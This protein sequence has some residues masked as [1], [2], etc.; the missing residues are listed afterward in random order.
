[1][2]LIL[3]C[4]C[5]IENHIWPSNK[6]DFVEEDSNFLLLAVNFIKVITLDPSE[7]NENYQYVVELL[8]KSFKL[9]EKF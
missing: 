6:T 9:S 7:N 3:S 1:M 4:T 2:S 8:L 5:I